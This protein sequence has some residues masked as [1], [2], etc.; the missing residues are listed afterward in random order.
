MLELKNIKKSFGKKKVLNGIDVKIENGIVGLLGVNGAGKTTL[1]NIIIDVLKPDDGEV[2]FNGKN[3]KTMKKEYRNE[4]GY[5]PQYCSYYPDFTAEEFLEYMCTIKGIKKDKKMI[6]ELLE[7]VNLLDEKDNKVG[8]FSG[9]MRQRLGIAQ[10][11][12]NNPK[13][14]ILDEPTAG[15][16]PEERIR[17]RNMISDIS[18]DRII[19]LA[20]HIVGDVENIANELIIMKDGLINIKGSPSDLISSLNNR[21][22]EVKVSEKDLDEFSSKY[23]ISNLYRKSDLLNARVVCDD[24]LEN[25]TECSANLEDVFLYYTKIRGNN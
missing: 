25:A 20:T 4:L 14:L 16:D 11:M 1:I 21:V 15:L 17:F 24:D 10:A 23:I 18:K 7:N 13:I 2:V 22:K 9:G 3:I 12:I 5:M 6:E 8:T 19:I